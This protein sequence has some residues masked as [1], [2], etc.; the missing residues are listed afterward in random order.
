GRGKASLVPFTSYPVGVAGVEQSFYGSAWEAC[1]RLTA[2]LM[3]KDSGGEPATAA[4][5]T[6]LG[7]GISARARELAVWLYT[8][9]EAHHRTQDALGCNALDASWPE[10]QRLMANMERGQQA[11][12]A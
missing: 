1:M 9:A 2:T 3:A 12:L 5:A 6:E 10:I 8:L 11:R 4:L 7:G